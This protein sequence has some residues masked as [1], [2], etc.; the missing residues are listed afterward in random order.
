MT[1]W[2]KLLAASAISAGTAWQLISSPKIG[3]GVVINDGVSVE[4]AT[5][6]LD[7]EVPEMQVEVELAAAPI[8]VEVA[9]VGID[10]EVESTPIEVEIST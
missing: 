5:Q 7:V 9:V 1:A 10:V 6:T 8:E 3:T 4:L 2:T